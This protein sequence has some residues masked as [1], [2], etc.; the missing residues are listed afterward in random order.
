MIY[1]IT[2][3]I[4]KET[5]DFEFHRNKVSLRAFIV[6]SA[7]NRSEIELFR[8]VAQYGIEKF[9][10]ENQDEINLSQFDNS[11]A[12]EKIEYQRLIKGKPEHDLIELEEK[13]EKKKTSTTKRRKKKSKKN[14]T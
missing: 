5:F 6:N 11:E 14:V 9:K 7:S 3:I 4:T 8:N 12:I 13:K 1:K 2:N 10:I